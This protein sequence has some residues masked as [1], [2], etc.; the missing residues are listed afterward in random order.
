MHIM[1]MF[2]KIPI[3]TP[4]FLIFSIFPLTPISYGGCYILCV[5]LRAKRAATCLAAFTD[6][7]G[8]RFYSMCDFEEHTAVDAIPHGLLM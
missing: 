7:A 2:M 3:N 1:H 4:I 8:A 5:L 6:D